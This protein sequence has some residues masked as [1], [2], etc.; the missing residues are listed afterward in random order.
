M[1]IRASQF[2]T[3]ESVKSG[4]RDEKNF[5]LRHLMRWRRNKAIFQGDSAHAVGWG[6]NSALAI[7]LF[8]FVGLGGAQN[9]VKQA[10]IV[11]H[12][13]TRGCRGVKFLHNRFFSYLCQ[14]S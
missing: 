8:A 5:A 4:V 10:R 6:D 3:W 12:S 1:D 14:H 9:L 11:L 13:K 7:D 2:G